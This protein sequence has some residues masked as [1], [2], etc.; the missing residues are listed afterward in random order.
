MLGSQQWTSVHDDT[1]LV[2]Y[3]ICHVEP[4]YVVMQEF[5]EAVVKYDLEEILNSSNESP[6]WSKV[7]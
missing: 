5:K 3:S 2:R 7:A 6:E 1:K 4:V